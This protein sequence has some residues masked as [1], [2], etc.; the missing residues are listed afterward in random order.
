MNM[1]ILVELIFENNN[2]QAEKFFCTLKLKQNM[3]SKRMDFSDH[4]SLFQDMDNFDI[5]TFPHPIESYVEC[6][7]LSIMQNSSQ[8]LL[9]KQIFH[10]MALLHS[11]LTWPH[12]VN[13]QILNGGKYQFFHT[14]TLLDCIAPKC[15]KTLI[16][17]QQI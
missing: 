11:H 9:Q 2:L 1:G 6:T 5:Y 15:L 13:E 10:S 7:L 16:F 17:L 12:K 4:S 3:L 14:K 8:E